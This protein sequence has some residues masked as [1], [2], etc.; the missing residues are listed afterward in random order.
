MIGH[1]DILNHFVG[2]DLDFCHRRI[3]T[4]FL[5]IIYSSTLLPPVNEMAAAC[6]QKWNPEQCSERRRSI[7]RLLSGETGCPMFL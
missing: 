2:I 5:V 4:S 6:Q 1:F 7:R 3:P